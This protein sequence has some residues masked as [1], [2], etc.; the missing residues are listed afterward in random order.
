MEGFGEQRLLAG[1]GTWQLLE[2]RR[3]S[4]ALSC[5]GGL[6]FVGRL[7]CLCHDLVG[8]RIGRGGRLILDYAR[9]WQGAKLQFLGIHIDYLDVPAKK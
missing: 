6:L 1:R 9:V 3:L 5:G 8:G 2:L 4:D 7:V